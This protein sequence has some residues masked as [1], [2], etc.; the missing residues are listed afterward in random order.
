MMLK[1]DF[2]AAQPII[3]ILNL[4]RLSHLVG[5]YV[6]QCLVA[7]SM[8]DG[9]LRS[10]HM[11][12]DSVSAVTT[13]RHALAML[14]APHREHIFHHFMVLL[15][16]LLYWLK[17]CRRTSLGAHLRSRTATGDSR[18][19]GRALHRQLVFLKRGAS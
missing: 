8:S 5:L 2:K 1:D 17:R 19:E 14:V 4:L 18:C 13:R 7:L 16:L 12:D 9:W 10:C 15:H 6:L 3:V 11:L